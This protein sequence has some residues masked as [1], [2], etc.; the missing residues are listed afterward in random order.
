MEAFAIVRGS[1]AAFERAPGQPPKISACIYS[2]CTGARATRKKGFLLQSL[3]VSAQVLNGRLCRR[4]I[5]APGEWFVPGY[6]LT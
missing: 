5:G 2:I 1:G 6:Q 3:C 4:G